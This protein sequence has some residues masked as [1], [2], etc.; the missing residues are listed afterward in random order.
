[1]EPLLIK[2]N[3]GPRSISHSLYATWHRL[4]MNMVPRM[5]EKAVELTV[6]LTIDQR[7]STACQHDEKTFEIIYLYGEKID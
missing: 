5:M 6:S 4:I 2:E 1:M 3:I 7:L